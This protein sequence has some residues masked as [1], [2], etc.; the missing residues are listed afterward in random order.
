MERRRFLS[1]ALGL[2]LAARAAGLPKAKIT[3]IRYFKT[4]TDAAG[5]PNTRQGLIN[6]STNVVLIETDAGLTGV[7]EGG[8]PDTMEQCAGLLIGEDPFR[9]DRL[10]QTMYRGYFYPAGREKAHSLGALDVAL[11]DLKAKAL[12]VPLY[13]LLGG[14]TRDYVE[15]YATGFPAKGTPREVA[16]ACIE[17]GFRAYR[18]SPAGSPVYDRFQAVKNAY[19]HCKEVREGA[20]KDGAWCIDFHTQL[21]FPDAVSLAN[22]IEPLKP[23]FVE[24]LVRSENPGVYRTLRGQVRVPIAVGEQFGP[25]WDWNE[26]IERQLIDYARVT[27]PNV[28]GVTEF[29]KIAAMCETHY[30]GLVPHFTG[31]ISEATMV[32]C[33][34]VF[35]GPVLMEMVNGGASEWS[36]LKTAYDLKN[37]K[38]WPNERLGIGVEVDTSKLQLIADHTVRY[39]TIP[40]IK[41]PDGSYTNW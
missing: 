19:E 7:G 37:G 21:D 12:G 20:G 18:I 16:R 13:Q 35:P 31:P 24:D 33:S 15:C 41:R 10:W 6:Q 30:V 11:W 23:Y 38:L 27:I 26:L 28:G 1:T 34:T 8:S 2:P 4:P 25:K 5:R 29:M 40:T 17:A 3:K 32:H 22:L 39:S 9:T 14:Q 36:Y